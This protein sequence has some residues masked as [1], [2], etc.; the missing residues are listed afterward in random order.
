VRV[1]RKAALIGALLGLF[2]P[3]ISLAVAIYVFREGKDEGYWVFWISPSMLGLMALEGVHSWLGALLVY[4][5]T[6]GLNMFLYAGIAWT[7][8]SIYSRA[9]KSK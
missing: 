3:P 7:G 4:L 6:F 5:V 9:I 8:A 2:V 1:T